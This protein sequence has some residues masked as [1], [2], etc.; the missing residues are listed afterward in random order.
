VCWVCCVL[1]VSV[2]CSCCTLRYGMLVCVATKT[3]RCQTECASSVTFI[4]HW[5]LHRLRK[6]FRDE[7]DRRDE[8]HSKEHPA[9]GEGDEND[10]IQSTSPPRH[11]HRWH[12][13]RRLALDVEECELNQQRSDEAAST[14]YRDQDADREKTRQ[15]TKSASAVVTQSE[16]EQCNAKRRCEM[17]ERSPSNP[18]CTNTYLQKL[19]A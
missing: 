9:V 15:Q 4:D 3:D 6:S 17:K 13:R 1:C 5:S 10:P 12:E 8:D 14:R 2:L 18:E 11:L 19:H 16:S 7:R